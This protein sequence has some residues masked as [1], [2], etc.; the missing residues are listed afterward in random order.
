MVHITA[1]DIQQMERIY[2]LNLINCISGYKSANLIGSVSTSGLLNLAIFNSVVHLG[3]EPPILGFIL[4]PPTVPRHTYQNIK[5]TGYF[6]INHIT[7]SMVSDAHHTSA[8][9]AETEQ[10]FDKISLNPSFLDGFIAPYLFESPIKIGC[11][12]LNEYP[13]EENGT[14]LILGKVEHLY[15]DETVQHEDGW[16]QLDKAGIVAIN[17]LDGYAKT[18]LIDRFAYARPNVKSKSLLK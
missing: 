18:N 1:A 11:K 14:I 2:R 16:L 12:Y 10:E 4:R 8:S 13:I 7:A 15:F 9:Y 3:S 5:K 17:G 6:T